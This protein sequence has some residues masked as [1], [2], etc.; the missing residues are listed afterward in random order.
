VLNFNFQGTCND[1]LAKD[2]SP[3]K[4]E[5]PGVYFA[6]TSTLKCRIPWLSSNSPEEHK[7]EMCS[8]LL[9]VLTRKKQTEIEELKL[10]ALLNFLQDMFPFYLPNR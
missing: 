1:S 8:L 5:Q 10:S 9:D 2:E 7:D 3:T 6:P 4:G